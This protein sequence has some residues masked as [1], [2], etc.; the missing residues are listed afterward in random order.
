LSR[1]KV[2]FQ[3]WPTPGEG[4]LAFNMSLE[5][6]F[7]N[8]KNPRRYNHLVTKVLEPKPAPYSI[9]RA[10]LDEKVAT[11]LFSAYIARPGF[12]PAYVSST[13]EFSGLLH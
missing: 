3:A 9:N 1:E 6:A 11:L 12:S 10:E 13:S 4:N 2:Y 8:S 7:Y 5:S